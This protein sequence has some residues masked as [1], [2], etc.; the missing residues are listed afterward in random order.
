M[1]HRLREILIC[2][3]EFPVSD[4]VFCLGAAVARVEAPVSHSSLFTGVGN[5]HELHK[6]AQVKSESLK[7]LYIF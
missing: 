5:S 2:M 7:E 3:H 6:L 4:Y 1:S